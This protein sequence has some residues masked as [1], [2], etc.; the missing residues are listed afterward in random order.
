MFFLI[1]ILKSQLIDPVHS[2]QIIKI[3]KTYKYL[4]FLFI[5]I[6]LGDFKYKQRR[7][8]N[9]F[10]SAI[11]STFMIINIK[12][13]IIF[14]LL[15]CFILYDFTKMSIKYIN[16]IKMYFVLPII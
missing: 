11:F 5:C 13:I 3:I 12:Q 1:F 8:Q 15:K 4:R 7:N 2:I 9:C 14:I 6:L 10:N 16:L